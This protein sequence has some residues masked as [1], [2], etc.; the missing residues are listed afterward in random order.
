[1]S[2]VFT[3]FFSAI[4]AFAILVYFLHGKQ[5]IEADAALRRHKI[6]L[7]HKAELARI[8]KGLPNSPEFE[9]LSEHFQAQ[10][11]K[12]IEE[13]NSIALNAEIVA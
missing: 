11:D 9:A 12:A 6:E 4:L 1:M 7:H 5:R 8:E 10:L 2:T 13:G 3:I